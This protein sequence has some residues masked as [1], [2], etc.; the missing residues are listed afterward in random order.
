VGRGAQ[1]F[2]FT[3]ETLQKAGAGWGITRQDLRCDNCG[4]ITSLA[5]GALSAACPFCASNKVN[6]TSAPSDQLRP[7]YLIPFPGARL[8]GQGLVP[9]A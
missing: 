6:L 5:Q 3:L 8:A 4:A 2:E 1:Q 7:R 9:P